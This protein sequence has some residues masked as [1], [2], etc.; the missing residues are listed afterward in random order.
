MGKNNENL[1]KNAEGY[2]DPTAYHAIKLAD[3]DYLFLR[4]LAFKKT[5]R[6]ILDLCELAGFQ[7][8]GRVILKDKKTGKVWK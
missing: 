5:L 7:V 6:N 2:S 8:E 1:R 4:E 3:E